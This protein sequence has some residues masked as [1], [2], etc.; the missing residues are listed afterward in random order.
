MFLYRFV[1]HN[2]GIHKIPLSETTI[3][4]FMRVSRLSAAALPLL[5]CTLNNSSSL[6]EANPGSGGNKTSD[7]FSEVSGDVIS[8]G[9]FW[10]QNI[11]MIL[12]VSIFSI[13]LLGL[14]IGLTIV[15][16]RKEK[17]RREGVAYVEDDDDET[18]REEV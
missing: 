5:I 10:R 16:R 7:D 4:S 15:D 3:L 12:V 14:S 2:C 8:Q 13:C 18:Y 6:V 17:Q 11:F 1:K 9:G